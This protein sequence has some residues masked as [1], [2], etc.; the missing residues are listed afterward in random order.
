MARL[1]LVTSA[2]ERSNQ[3]VKERKSCVQIGDSLLQRVQKVY[4]MVSCCRGYTELE[5][6]QFK[7]CMSNMF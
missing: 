5:L 2:S 4:V 3:K 7:V 6:F 1:P